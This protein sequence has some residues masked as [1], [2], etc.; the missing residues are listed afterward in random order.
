MKKILFLLTVLLVFP[1][2]VSAQQFEPRPGL[3]VILPEVSD[4]WQ[5]GAEAPANLLEHMIEHL[6]EDAARSGQS[7]TEEQLS[8]AA[9]QRLATND[10]FVFNPDSGAH[11]LISFSALDKNEAPPSMRAIELSARYAADGVVDE[12]WENV[13]VRQN[14]AQI[15]GAASAQRFEID[16]SHEGE[17]S[18]FVGVV[19]FAAPYWFWLYANDHLADPEDRQVIETLLSGIRLQVERQK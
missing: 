16:Y 18:R 7:P 9:Q 8:R 5:A 12:G 11:L 19:G 13:K 2:F 3:K 15:D 14:S 10:L 6:R 17:D 1:L 4:A